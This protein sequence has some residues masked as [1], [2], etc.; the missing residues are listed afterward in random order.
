MHEKTW[1]WR[2]LNCSLCLV[3]PVAKSAQLLRTYLL[4]IYCNFLYRV[5]HQIRDLGFVYLLLRYCLD[6]P[7][8][9]GQGECGRMGIVWQQ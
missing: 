4:L 1:T 2:G 3:V 5:G 8:L 7:V 6:N 9:P